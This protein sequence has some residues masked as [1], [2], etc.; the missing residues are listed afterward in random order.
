MSG[1]QERAT[2]NMLQ[3]TLDLT[4]A[5]WA[6]SGN[7]TRAMNATGPDGVANSACTITRTGNGNVQIGQTLRAVPT[8]AW[9]PTGGPVVASAWLRAATV[10]ARLARIAA[11]KTGADG[12]V[13]DLADTVRLTDRWQRYQL[14]VPWMNAGDALVLRIF[15][16]RATSVLDTPAQTMEVFSPQIEEGLTPTQTWPAPGAARAE[17]PFNSL[18]LGRNV[19]KYGTAP[20][21]VSA[22]RHEVGDRVMN[23]APAAGGWAGWV[24]VTAGSPGTWKGFGAIEA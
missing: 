23:A 7:A 3:E 6:L 18:L 4:T 21:S 8:G 13:T 17:R 16:G 20:P 12:Y 22:G 1:V 14:N 15:L 24:C 10:T 5:I 11:F 9:T 2:R 19:I